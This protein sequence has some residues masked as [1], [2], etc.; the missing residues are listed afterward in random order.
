MGKII[1]VDREFGSGGREFGRLLAEKLGY[2]YVDNELLIELIHKES[3]YSKEFLMTISKGRPTPKFN[4]HTAASFQDMRNIQSEDVFD[5]QA[6]MMISIAKERDCVVVGRCADYVLREFNPYRIF[7]Y[8]TMESK[9]ARC[10]KF[11]RPEDVDK[12]DRQL[13]KEIKWIDRKRK[14]NYEYYTPQEWGRHFN[15][16]LM[17][18]TSSRSVEELVDMIYRDVRE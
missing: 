1:T 16:D 17:I 6:E 15:Y 5:H 12:S 13:E 9:I 14:I 8:G 18:N 7:V 4:F 2:T 10:R 3:S 11:A